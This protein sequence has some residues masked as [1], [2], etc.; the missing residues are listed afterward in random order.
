MKIQSTK[1]L[2]Q[3]VLTPEIGI[4]AISKAQTEDGTHRPSRARAGQINPNTRRTRRVL[5]IEI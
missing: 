5:N 3:T 2:A 1:S 4:A